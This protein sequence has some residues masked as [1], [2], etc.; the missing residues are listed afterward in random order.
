M[1]HHHS[2][3]QTCSSN[4]SAFEGGSLIWTDLID[5]TTVVFFDFGWATL[6]STFL[7]FIVSSVS[8]VT[9]FLGTGFRLTPQGVSVAGPLPATVRIVRRVTVR[10]PDEVASPG[11][12]PPLPPRPPT[13][14]IVLTHT[15]EKWG[16]SQNISP[17]KLCQKESSGTNM[18]TFPS[19]FDTNLP[20][21]LFERKNHHHRF[22]RF[23]LE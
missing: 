1:Q 15:A 21:L 2:R 8:S 17:S 14:L 20:S 16:D 9:T 4:D 23:P 5:F 19:R 18:Y 12:K 6:G 10:A 13:E 11:L 3:Q 7:D 22:L